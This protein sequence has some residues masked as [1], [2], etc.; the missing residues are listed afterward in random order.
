[1][2]QAK[3]SPAWPLGLNAHV[4]T[5]TQGLV[6]SVEVTSANVYDAPVLEACWCGEEE[7]YGDKAYVSASSEEKAK[8]RGMTGRVLRKATVKRKPNCTDQS[9][10][11]KS[12][13]IRA[14]VEPAFGVVQSLWG[15]RKVRYR[16]WAKSKPPVYALFALAHIYM[17]REALQG[18]SV[19]EALRLPIMSSVQRNTL[20]QWA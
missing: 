5:D 8:A 7:I 12:N 14:R 9:F 1:M 18:R 20:I 6:P 16:G 11:K 3:E 15:Y 10:N 2:K 19:L 4:D 13:R 17:A